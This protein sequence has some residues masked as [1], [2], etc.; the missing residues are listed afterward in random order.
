[1]PKWEQYLDEENEDN[2]KKVE[3]IRKNPSVEI[4]D[5]KSPPKKI[6]RPKRPETTD[7]RF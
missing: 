4:K 2:Y 1:M 7:S 6:K 3:R 5:D